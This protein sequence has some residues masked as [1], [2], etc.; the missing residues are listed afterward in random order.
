MKD[1]AFGRYYEKNRDV[2]LEKMRD[3]ERVRREERNKLFELNPELKEKYNEKRREQ[4]RKRVDKKYENTKIRLENLI[5]SVCGVYPDFAQYLKKH[6]IED[7]NYKT[8]DEETLKAFESKKPKEGE[9]IINSYVLSK[10]DER[11][12]RK[13]RPDEETENVVEAEGG[14]PEEK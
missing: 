5:E 1:N 10:E 2:L 4:Y 8:M 6:F 14:E 7:G 11:F 3:R 9:T 12:V 13:C